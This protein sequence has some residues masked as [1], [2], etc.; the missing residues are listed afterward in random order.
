MV[1]REEKV[2]Y[3]AGGVECHGLLTYDSSNAGK[4][5]AI[6]VIHAWRGQDGFAREKTRE[7]AD[8][9]YVGFAVDLYGNGQSVTEDSEAQ[10]LMAPL[11]KNRKK[12][13]ERIRAAYEFLRM[14]DLVDA[15]KMG[16]IGF[17]F[18]GLTVLE[19]LR[20]GASLKGAVSFH[21]LLGDV[22]GD[23]TAVKEPVN[24]APPGALLLL[25]GYEDT[26]T[27]PAEI[28][29]LQKEL[30]DVQMDWQM[31]IY[32]QTCHAFMN[33][34]AANPEKGMVYNPKIAL[35]AWHAMKNFFE[36]HLQ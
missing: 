21:G 31:N 16:A 27:P 33:P 23:I 4:K 2:V 12:L 6:L 29:R 20:S 18:G 14:S 7:L 3:Q 13:R 10:V 28:A 30:N 5:P 1:M 11:F 19:L 25:H 9:G 22:M 17:C 8:L 36:E 24:Y 35:R 34:A 26:F 32:G 15:S